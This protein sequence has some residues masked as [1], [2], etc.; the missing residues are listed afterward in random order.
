M[1]GVGMAL[2]LKDLTDDERLALVALLERVVEAD[3]Y[4]TESEATH[5][6]AVIDAIGDE[7]YEAAADEVDR[8]FQSHEELRRFL[9]TIT[10]TEAREL[11]YETLIE[12]ALADAPVKAEREFLD[13]VA[14]AWNIQTRIVSDDE[15]GA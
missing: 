11:I 1:K 12:A 3:S 4:V 2:E 15:T 7:A 6:H 13:W 10:R 8:R 9:D 5:V 14:G